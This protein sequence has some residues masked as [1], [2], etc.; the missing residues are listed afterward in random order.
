VHHVE[1]PAVAELDA[2][3]EPGREDVVETE[4]EPRGA[5]GGF[6]D[7]RDPGAHTDAKAPAPG[8]SVTEDELREHSLANLAKYKVP[9]RWLFVDG[10]P[11]NAMG[12]IQKPELKK[13]FGPA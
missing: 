12:K 5:A 7:R 1:A 6:A 8:A 9:E 3:G 10:F 4:V 2:G 13:R 11:R